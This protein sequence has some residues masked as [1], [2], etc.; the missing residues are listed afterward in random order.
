MHRLMKRRTTMKTL[1][2]IQ[3]QIRVKWLLGALTASLAFTA[4]AN[5]APAFSGRFVL[6]EEV[7]WNHAVLPAGEYSIYMKSIG[8]PA[9]VHSMSSGKSFYTGSPMLAQ[10]AT[11]T[12]QL[13]VTVRGNER[14]VRSL[15]VPEIHATLIFD[16]LT[17][18]EREE[19][20]QSEKT[21]TLAVVTAAK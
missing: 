18:A 19:L 11:G 10:G 3:R 5:A 6:P 16:P 21:E 15:T 8:A 1:S 9:L 12:A 13:N 7:R 14:R 4:V 2:T 20:A 17:K